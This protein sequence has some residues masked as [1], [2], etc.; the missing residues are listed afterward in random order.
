[1]RN[2]TERLKDILNAIDDLEEFVG[3]VSQEEFLSMDRTDRRTFR[4]VCDCL[5][6]IGEAAKNLPGD[7]TARH[8]DINWAGHAGMGDILTH[9][10]FRVRLDL[11]WTTIKVDLPLLRQAVTRELG[12]SG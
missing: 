6:T 5:S 2:P 1:M 4:A 10:Y 7:L 11:I 8:A 3:T 9:Q 12:E